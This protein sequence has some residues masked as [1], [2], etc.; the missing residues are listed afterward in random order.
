MD[1][2]TDH[3]GANGGWPG[4]IEATIGQQTAP[5]GPPTD[6]VFDLLSQSHRRFVLYCLHRHD[7]AMDLPRLVDS[8]VRLAETSRVQ[9][10]PAHHSVSLQLTHATLPRLADADVVVYDRQAGV[11]W[12]TEAVA[13]MEPLLDLAAELDFELEPPLAG[14][15]VE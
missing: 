10:S 6:V 8:V 14:N 12:P 3:R 2:E 5:E 13:A 4:A 11:V 15:Y 1:D 9:A 7:G